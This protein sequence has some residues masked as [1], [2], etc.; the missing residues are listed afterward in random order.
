[1]TTAVAKPQQLASTLFFQK[2]VHCEGQTAATASQLCRTYEQN[3]CCAA[4]YMKPWTKT[5]CSCR[6]W[7]HLCSFVS[8]S[9]DAA[10]S[11]KSNQCLHLCL[12]LQLLWKLADSPLLTAFV[13]TS[14]LCFHPL[15]LPARPLLLFLSHLHVPLPSSHIVHLSCQHLLSLHVLIFSP[16]LCFSLVMLPCTEGCCNATMAP[17]VLWT[18]AD[19]VRLDW[20]SQRKECIIPSQSSSAW[21]CLS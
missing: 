18:A 19:L 15:P 7:Q 9:I 10:K 6:S 1:M 12:F 8:D 5:L 13:L 16:G 20:K 14:G 4:D 21:R 2:M 11:Q 3:S 17:S